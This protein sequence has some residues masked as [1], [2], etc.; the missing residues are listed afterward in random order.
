M[1]LFRRLRQLP[2]WTRTL[3]V[4][5][6]VLF[7]GVSTAWILVE[8]ARRSIAGSVAVPYGYDEADERALV[9]QRLFFAGFAWDQKLGPL[10]RFDYRM[11]LSAQV[12]VEW[13][14][15]VGG[16]V[17]VSTEKLTLRAQRI[18]LKMPPPAAVPPPVVAPVPLPP[19]RP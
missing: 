3:I 4:V 14:A 19:P 2:W 16:I 15:R 11:P 13:S 7:V 1:P 17:S 9:R 6:V 12:Y 8:Y 5:H 18:T 10:V